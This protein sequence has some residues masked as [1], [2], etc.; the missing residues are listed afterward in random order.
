M[1]IDSKNPCIEFTEYAVC[2]RC[3]HRAYMCAEKDNLLL[4]F[5][6]HHGFEY[7]FT[8]EEDGWKIVWDVENYSALVPEIRIQENDSVPV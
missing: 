1:N 7:E 8:L 3:H 5:C 6:G 2:D 4:S